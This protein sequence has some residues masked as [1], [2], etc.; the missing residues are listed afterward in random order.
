MMS[1]RMGMPRA[2]ATRKWNH[3]KNSPPASF[4]MRSRTWSGAGWSTTSILPE[5][6]ALL[7]LIPMGRA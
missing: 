6:K 5:S 4:R 7:M 2:P 3:C 1:S